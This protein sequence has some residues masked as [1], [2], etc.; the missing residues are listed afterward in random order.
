MKKKSIFLLIGVI[1]CMLLACE[2]RKNIE[3]NQVNI[4]NNMTATEDVTGDGEEKLSV[5][6]KVADDLIVNE[7]KKLVGEYEYPSNYGMGKL[8]IKESDYGYDISDYESQSSY[9]FLADSSNIENIENS[10]IYIKYPEQVFQDD[11]VIFSYYI[12]EY[13][14][15]EIDVYY[16]QS[17]HAEEQLLYHATKKNEVLSNYQVKRMFVQ[18]NSDEE[19]LYREQRAVYTGFLRRYG[20]SFASRYGWRDFLIACSRFAGGKEAFAAFLEQRKIARAGRAKLEV[21][22]KILLTHP[23][24]RIIIFTA[25]NDTAYEIGRRFIF[26]VLTHHTKSAERKAFLD[27]F[28]TG[29]Y[30]VLVTSKVLN[31]GV[32]IPSAAVGVVFSGSGSVRE[33]VQRLGRILRPSPGKSQAMLY[34]LVSAGT[35]EEY[36]SGRRREHRAYR[37][38]R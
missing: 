5:S 6:P 20:I 9:R 25:D 33:H 38:R 18:L 7:L 15:D 4:S 17:E 23:G 35:S 37:K 16:R 24:E 1:V 22:E 26:P 14:A 30:P 3:Y 29:D 28:R 8:I 13:S 10:R 19:R 12:L 21:L 11:T 27:A 2:Q 31:E 36:T 32:D 34:E